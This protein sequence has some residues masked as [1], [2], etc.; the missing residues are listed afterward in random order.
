[1]NSTASA[2]APRT[3]FSFYPLLFAPP[4]L[5]GLFLRLCGLSGQ[6][7]VDDEWHSLNFVLDKSGW[8]VL[9][10]HGLGANCIPQ[11]FVN[12]IMLHTVGWSEALLFLPSVLCGIAGLLVFPW[13]VSRLA[14]RTVAVLFSWL[15]A[16]SPCVVFYSRIVRPYPMVLFF[17][18]LSLL[19]LA[20]WVRE[21]HRR[22]LAT[23]AISGFAAID[24]HL[25]AAL[26]VLAPLGALLILVLLWRKENPDAP[27]ISAKTLAGVGL[28]MAGLL[29]IFLGP[30]HWNNPWW[31]NV[32]AR[33]RVT[34]Q[35]LWDFLSFLAGTDFV[36]GKLVFGVLI[37]YGLAAWLQKEFRVGLLWVSVWAAFFLLLI[38]ATQDG[39]HAAIQIARYNIVLFPTGMLLAAFALESL[40]ARRSAAGRVA[41]GSLLIGGLIAGSPLWRTCD[42]PNNF[43]HHSAFQDS[44]APFDWS[45]SRLRLLTP[46][47][48]MPRERIP[49]FYSTLAADAAVPGI[50]EYPMYI[51]DPLNFHYFYQHVHRKPVAVGYVPDDPFAPLPSRDD[52][53]YQ[54]TPVDYVLSR[55]RALGLDSRMRFSNLVPITDPARLRRD[56]SG[57]F[58]IVH[59]DLLQETLNVQLA[60]GN[61]LPS[62]RLLLALEA[63]LGPPEHSD[64]QLLAW[65]IP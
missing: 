55:A 36:L 39:M 61:F 18:F 50:L 1:M 17:G 33:D 40:F 43:M 22:Y 2:A 64:G 7:L 3:G 23:Y 20:L 59:R 54:D 62:A 46:M 24:G 44:Y 63:D 45:R 31:L 8:A 30:A 60:G 16:I 11:N 53:I 32:L 15:L 58:L 49:A 37:G 25:Y 28:L 51:G 4:V 12:W 14:G 41:A 19:C 5:V 42:R 56:H 38:F 29:A 35:G 65:R 27:W 34:A 13:L 9:T 26:P 48:Q 57:W 47:P 6:V 21:G 10:T 52:F